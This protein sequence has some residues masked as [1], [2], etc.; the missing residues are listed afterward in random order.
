MRSEGYL[1]DLEQ[2]DRVVAASPHLK[3]HQIETMRNRVERRNP[4]PQRAAAMPAAVKKAALISLGFEVG[5]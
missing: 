5:F 4:S 2:I 3:N 1:S